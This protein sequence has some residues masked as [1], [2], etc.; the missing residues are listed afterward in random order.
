MLA[1]KYRDGVEQQ[2]RGD[3]CSDRPCAQPLPGTA[4]EHRL[5]RI[6]RITPKVRDDRKFQNRCEGLHA[7]ELSLRRSAV[8]IGA[9]HDRVERARARHRR[10]DA[11][12]RNVILALSPQRNRRRAEQY[13]GISCGERAEQCLQRDR[14]PRRRKQIERG[15]RTITD[16]TPYAHRHRRLEFHDAHHVEKPLGT[17]EMRDEHRG[18]GNAERSRDIPARALQRLV[19]RAPRKSRQDSAAAHDAAQKQIRDDFPLPVRLFEQRAIEVRHPFFPKIA[20]PN[21]NSVNAVSAAAPY[22]AGWRVDGST[23][24]EGRL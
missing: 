23:G 20:R 6:A 24:R 14:Y 17:S 2:R 22:P 12:R 1:S 21:A 13:A 10:A 11:H 18:S 15:E 7:L 8:P 4:L 3:P 5:S 9:Q 19:S 16:Q